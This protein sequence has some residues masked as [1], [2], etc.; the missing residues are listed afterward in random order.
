VSRAD[1]MNVGLDA[2]YGSSD[3]VTVYFRLGEAF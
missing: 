2:A 3:D 1:R